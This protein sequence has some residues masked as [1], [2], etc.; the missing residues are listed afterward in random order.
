MQAKSILDRIVADVRRRLDETPE[1][2]GLEAAAHAAAET[3]RERGLRSLRG[4]ISGPGPAVI[5]ECKKASPSAGVIRA[6]FDP[7]ALA[8]AYA[9]GGAA[10]ISVV[11]EP[12]YFS[13]DPQWLAVIRRAVDL[14]VL[15]KDFLVT[16]R[17]LH[18]S[19][20][21]GADA[22]LLIS[23]ILDREKLAELLASAS[24]LDLEVLLEIFVDEDPASAVD[25]GAGII[26]VNARDLTTF[27]TRLDRVEAMASKLPADRVL[28]AESGIH[29]PD[30]LVRLHAANYDAFLVG[31]HLVRAEDPAA[32]VQA[33][34]GESASDQ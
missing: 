33:L 1:M 30:D 13:G 10:A 7:V 14:P 18:E 28:V 15:R 32:A 24:K 16:R 26:G 31:E 2:P 3:R 11:T 23:R 29:G 12:E 20:V 19:A 6:E 8:R 25:S 5:A 27:E 9:E 4:A 34:L 17:Q 21:L 22:V